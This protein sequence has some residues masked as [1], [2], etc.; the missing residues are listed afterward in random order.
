MDCNTLSSEQL[1]ILAYSAKDANNTLKAIDS[2]KITRRED[3]EYLVEEYG[4]YKPNAAILSAVLKASNFSRQDFLAFAQKYKNPLLWEVLLKTRKV[5]LDDIKK[6]CGAAMVEKKMEAFGLK[7]KI[8]VDVELLNAKYTT[9]EDLIAAIRQQ[10][11]Q[12]E[13]GYVLDV[14]L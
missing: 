3:W 13:N 8:E 1:T 12:S 14:L 7:R 2:G 4:D 5:S 6:V 10:A 11:L 9:K